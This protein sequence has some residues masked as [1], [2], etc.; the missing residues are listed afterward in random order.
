MTK[1]WY[2]ARELT[3]PTGI[4]GLPKSQR[5]VLRRAKREGWRF[6]PRKGRGGGREFYIASL[7]IES[8]K[9]LIQGQKKERRQNSPGIIAR[10]IGWLPWRKS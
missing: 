1:V 7:P 9:Y 10:L 4:P 6:R 8:Q 3:Q 5:G 2:S